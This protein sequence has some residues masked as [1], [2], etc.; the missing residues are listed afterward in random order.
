MGRALVR[1]PDVAT[2]GSLGIAKSYFF[3]SQLVLC[4]MSIA[5]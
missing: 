5:V 2:R 4:G 3:I 1:G